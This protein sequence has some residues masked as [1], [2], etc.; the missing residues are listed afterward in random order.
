MLFR[1]GHLTININGP[2]G[3][4]DTMTLYIH[5]DD[6]DKNKNVSGGTFN[7]SRHPYT[8]TKYSGG[9]GNYGLKVDKQTVYS[10]AN[11]GVITR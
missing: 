11:G 6:Y 3:K 8:I 4:K 10:E 7:N 1:S 5:S 2:N 9:G